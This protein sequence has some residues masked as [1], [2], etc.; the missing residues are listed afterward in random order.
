MGL[1]PDHLTSY[2]LICPVFYDIYGTK[3]DVLK[4]VLYAVVL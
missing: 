2:M 3:D 4:Y 1:K